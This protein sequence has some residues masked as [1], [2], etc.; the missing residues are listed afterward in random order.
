M[1]GLG[2]KYLADNG[3]IRR[4]D[5]SGLVAD[6]APSVLASTLAADTSGNVFALDTSI[7][8]IRRITSAG[9]V[10]NLATVNNADTLAVDGAGVLY[11]ATR[12]TQIF[13]LTP[14]N[15]VK[16]FAGKP[17]SYGSFADGMGTAVSFGGLTGIAVDS[18]SPVYVA[19]YHNQA[20]RR[21]SPAGQVTT[22]ARGGFSPEVSR[23]KARQP[24]STGWACGR[25]VAP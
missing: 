17:G 21:I 25:L 24:C 19:D 2:N 7:G 14:D 23:P 9:L 1:D 11:I 12:D 15:V 16:P 3:A 18:E 5:A 4:M 6:F 13:K 20:V 8:T 10:T 22:L